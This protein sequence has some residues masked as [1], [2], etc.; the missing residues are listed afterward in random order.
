V[1]Q[2]DYDAAAIAPIFLERVL[3]WFES[4]SEQ[5]RTSCLEVFRIKDIDMDTRGDLVKDICTRL[6]QLRTGQS[7]PPLKEVL[8]TINEQ[9][10]LSWGY[11][12]GSTAKELSYFTVLAEAGAED[13]LLWVDALE[14]SDSRIRMLGVTQIKQSLAAH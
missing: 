9:S 10:N 4:P 13:A 3:K 8:A 5:L 11:T 6:K 12:Y 2:I 14:Y 1:H 7:K